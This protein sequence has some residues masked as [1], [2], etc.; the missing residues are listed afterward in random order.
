MGKSEADQYSLSRDSFNKFNPTLL[1]L[2]DLRKANKSFE[3]LAAVFDLQQFTAFC[4]QRDPHLEGTTYSPSSYSEA[5]PV[6]W[7]VKKCLL[8]FTGLLADF[9]RYVGIGN[10]FYW[11]SSSWFYRY[12]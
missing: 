7:W 4:D 3:G 5:S 11:Y 2:G 8:G 10:N 12:Q 9:V 6:K 1:G